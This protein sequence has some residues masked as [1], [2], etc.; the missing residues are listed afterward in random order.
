MTLAAA[1]HEIRRRARRLLER[2]RIRELRQPILP[3]TAQELI[4][5]DGEAVQ[6][7][8]AFRDELGPDLAAFKKGTHL[9]FKK[10]MRPLFRQVPFGNLVTRWVSRPYAWLWA[11][12]CGKPVVAPEVESMKVIFHLQR[13]GVVLPRLLAAGQN[14][15]KPWEIQS[16][17]LTQPLQGALPLVQFLATADPASRRRAVREAGRVL[18]Q[19]HA[20]N[21]Y[22]E[23]RD[24]AGI[25]DLLAVSC[26]GAGKLTVALTTV[27]GIEK[28]R[29]AN[30]A[31]VQ[32]DLAALARVPAGT[33]SQTDL[34]RGLLSYVGRPR[35][36]VGTKAFASRVLSRL[37]A[38]KSLRRIAA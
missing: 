31:R 11:W 30:P 2:R 7:T 8:P 36:T 5:L 21:C 10:E 9:F 22:V 34:L 27:H 26:S 23:K 25:A 13:Y 28:T 24:G 32:R 6:V 3:P 4:W 37:S 20:A 14:N 12:L 1:A 35:L 17:L 29:H 16:F 38:S 18:R 33:C 19:M 15:I